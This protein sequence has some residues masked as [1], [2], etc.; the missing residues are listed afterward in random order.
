MATAKFRRSPENP[1]LRTGD[2]LNHRSN[3]ASSIAASHS[4]AGFTSAS[5][6]CNSRSALT[7]TRRREFQGQTSWQISHP[8]TCRP[9]PS[10]NPAS[11]APRCSMVKYEMHRA[12]SIW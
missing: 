1:A 7:T 5:R 12:A 2:P 3:S 9:I 6:A 4:S 8:K 10:I 11:I